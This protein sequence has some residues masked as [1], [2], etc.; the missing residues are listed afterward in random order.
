MAGG[1]EK[2]ESERTRL[3]K[4]HQYKRRFQTFL[5]SLSFHRKLLGQVSDLVYHSN[6]ENAQRSKRI[7]PSQLHRESWYPQRHH[8]QNPIDPGILDLRQEF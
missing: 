7:R 8:Q 3:Q 5:P 4:Y 1:V 6:E 2:F